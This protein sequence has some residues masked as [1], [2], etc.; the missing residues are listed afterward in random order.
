MTLTWLRA[1]HPTLSYDSYSIDTSNHMLT[2]I[3]HFSL[4]PDITFSPSIQIPMNRE[5]DE[6]TLQTLVFHLGLVESISYW[7]AACSPQ[8]VVKAGYL[9]PEQINW[10]HDLFVKSLGEFFY[11]NHI[12]FTQP[13]FLTITSHSSPQQYNN[14]TMKQLSS[15]D[16]VMVGGG[17]DSAVTLELLRSQSVR[18]NALLVNPTPSA[19]NITKL[20]GY[21]ALVVKRTM[22]PKLSDLNKLGYLNGHTPFSALLAFIGITTAVLNGYKNVIASNEQSASEGNILF[23]GAEV[24]HQYSKSFEF[25]KNFREYCVKFLFRF[26]GRS[27]EGGNP[28]S[29]KDWTPDQVRGDSTKVECFSVLRPLYDLQIAKI[30]SKLPQYHAVF[31]SCNVGRG[32]DWC[33]TCPKCAFVFLALSA[34]LP[35]D[36]MVHIFGSDYFQHAAIVQHIAHL[37]GLDGPKPFECV[38]TKEES[39]VALLLTQQRYKASRQDLPTSITKL[40][41]RLDLTINQQNNLIE[42]TL[43]NW[44]PHHFLPTEYENLLKKVT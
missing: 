40:I 1:R 15:G 14:E 10:W 3:F 11:K 44:N 34:F 28:S 12:N 32:V 42:E 5:I 18:R 20:A 41:N 13:N 27:R 26:V 24:N 7:K 29:L 43:D 37:I 25:E 9:S 39:T 17:K 6:I 33:G 8:F 16:L 35:K 19:V 21:D 2:A 4:A 22:D 38:G 36:V 23:H 30:F 31:R